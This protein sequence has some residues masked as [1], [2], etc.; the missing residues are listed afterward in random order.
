MIYIKSIYI[1]EDY[2]LSLHNHPVLFDNSVNCK[3]LVDIPN[4]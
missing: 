1:F 3:F 4:D 2:N